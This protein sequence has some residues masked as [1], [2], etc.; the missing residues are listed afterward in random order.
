MD[1][2]NLGALPVSES[3]PQGND[4]RYDDLFQELSTEIDKLSS[5]SERENFSWETVITL[6]TAILKDHSKDLLVASYLSVALVHIRK[7]KGLDEATSIFKDLI[8]GYWETLYPGKNREKG[9]ISALNWWVEKTDQA[10]DNDRNWS[11]TPEQ[12]NTMADR[13]DFVDS[14]LKKQLPGAPSLSSL[15][16]KIRNLKAEDIASTP[17]A[18]PEKDK[19]ADSSDLKG[20]DL[21]MSKMIT[22]DNVDDAL[23]K[24]LPLFQG[25]KQTASLLREEKDF[26][27]Q[28]YHFLRFAIWESVRNLPP[29]ADRITRLNPPM[30]QT[31]SLLDNLLKDDDFKALIHASETALVSSKHIFFLDLNHYTWKALNGLGE[32]Y[33]AARDLVFHETK[34]FLDRLE[35]LDQLLFSDGTPFLSETTREWLNSTEND[36]QSNRGGLTFGQGDTHDELKAEINTIKERLDRNGSLQEAVDLFQEKINS[37]PSKKDT[38]VLRMGLARLL[39]SNKQGR[40]AAAQMESVLRDLDTHHLDS[41][42]PGLALSTLKTI[43][44]AYKHHEDPRYRNKAMD[45]IA[46][47]ARISATEAMKL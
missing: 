41:W 29:S 43:F 1:Y 11:L 36:S 20:F 38:M 45:I 35:G 24:I 32:K 6:A 47:I 34:G 40:M 30:A 12:A 39:S 4:I 37:C 19:K 26:N 10:L 33:R 3:N 13:L 2:H 15:V 44:K 14:F 31:R 46:R 25:L 9:R 17:K 18:L 27:P 16:N 42:D 21:D 8:E 7:D 22:L 5:A 23:K 28:A